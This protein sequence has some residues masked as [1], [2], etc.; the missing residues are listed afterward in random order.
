M[1][2]PPG[3]PDGSPLSCPRLSPL[4]GQPGPLARVSLFFPPPCCPSGNLDKQTGKGSTALHYCCLTDNAECLKLLLRGKA[5]IEIGESAGTAAHLRSR[6]A[7]GRPDRPRA[8]PS[9]GKGLPRQS[10][11]CSAASPP[12]AFHCSRV[13]GVRAEE[14][15]GIGQGLGHLSLLLRAHTLDLT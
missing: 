13:V 5:S 6:G 8:V 1:T 11:Y 9:E 2:S 10:S 12:W 4:P 7:R 3:G 14:A 15:E